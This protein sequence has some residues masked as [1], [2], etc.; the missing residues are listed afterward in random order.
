MTHNLIKLANF[1]NIMPN[2]TQCLYNSW[3]KS[4]FDA[5]IGGLLPPSAPQKPAGRRHGLLKFLIMKNVAREYHSLGLGL[6]FPTH[7]T[8]RHH[9]T[10]D[11]TC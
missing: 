5:Q 4:I 11:Q 6:S 3:I 8:V 9:A 2:I 7:G 1:F 10:I